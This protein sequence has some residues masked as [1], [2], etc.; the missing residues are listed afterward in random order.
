MVPRGESSGQ[1]DVRMKAVSNEVS[2][3]EEFFSLFVFTSR[4]DLIEFELVR[5]KAKLEELEN[6]ADNLEEQGID[7]S[8]VRDKLDEAENKIDI[9]EEYLNRKL[10]DASLDAVYTAWKLLR[11]AEDMLEELKGG[12]QLPWWLIVIIVFIAAILI[13]T[14]VIRRV[15]KNLRMILRGRMSEARMVA[16]SVK[17]S[18]IEI[19]R[20][21][22][23]RIKAERTLKLLENQYKQGIISKAAYESMKKRSEGKVKD[24][25]RKI[26]ERLMR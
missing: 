7:V 11:E 10:Y 1:Y 9:A 23:E 14:V 13:L 5:L 24:L 12:F 15:T 20:M 17:G 18:G 3:S 22:D 4:K 26:K 19:D 2:S 21:K 6:E 25:D 16:E 8:D